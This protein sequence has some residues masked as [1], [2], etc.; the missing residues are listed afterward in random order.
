MEDISRGLILMWLEFF[1]FLLLFMYSFYLFT[2]ILLCKI[3]KKYDTNSFF[4]SLIQVIIYTK[5]ILM[6]INEKKAKWKPKDEPE[7]RCPPSLT[8]TSQTMGE[9]VR[10]AIL[11]DLQARKVFGEKQHAFT[12]GGLSL[13][14]QPVPFPVTWHRITRSN[15]SG[16]YKQ[17]QQSYQWKIYIL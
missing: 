2:C 16:L 11:T 9:V 10:D 4:V 3:I 17:L 13:T 1:F 14:N 7:W 5:L 15:E 12:Q 6:Q 8:S